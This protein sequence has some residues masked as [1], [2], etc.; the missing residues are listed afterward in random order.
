MIHLQRVFRF[1][2]L[3]LAVLTSSLTSYGQNTGKSKK[4]DSQLEIGRAIQVFRSV[5]AGVETLYVDTVD[6]KGISARGINTMLSQLD[7]YTE[8]MTDNESKDFIFMTTGAY[9]G[10]GAYIQ[11]KDSA[12]Y[13]QMPMPGTPAEKSGLKMGDKFVVIEGVPVVPATAT[14]V[15]GLLKGQ[16]GTKVKVKILRL[17][18]TKEREFT[19]TRDN[20]VV[21]QVVHRGIYR[22]NIGYIR[23]SSF[24]NKSAEDVRKA[25]NELNSTRKLKS[26][27]LDLRGNGGGV[28]D[29]AIKILGMFLPEKTLVLYTEG[30]LPETSQKYYT[31]DKPIDTNIPVVVLINGGSASASEIVSGAMQDLDRGVVLGSKSF[32]KGLVQSTRP[33]PNKGILKVTIARYYIP[34]GRCIQQLDY[35]HRNPDG[36]VASVP[37][38]LANQ[39]KTKNGRIV[40]DGGGIRPDLEIQDEILPVSVFN[41]IRGGYIFEFANKLFVN[42]KGTA[43]PQ[44]V[45]DIGVTDKDF[46]DFLT[47]LEEQKFEYGKLSLNALNRLRE[48]AEFEGYKEQSKE[49]FKELEKALSPSL[50][51]DL[52]QH[53]DMIISQLRSSLASHYFGM[54]GQY[55]VGLESDPTFEKALEILSNKETYR[56]LL[57]PQRD[58]KNIK[59]QK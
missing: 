18:E 33:L 34:S 35:S 38:S 30:K 20:V 42:R 52:A 59:V 17:G 49:A 15:S 54:S 6:I 28:M 16:V 58:S 32:G 1:S 57:T 48:L 47:Y 23:L 25:Y 21:D 40:K 5:L 10:I 36:S 29:D 8:Y 46:E 39:F 41:M 37:D 55:T 3:L 50:R 27:I 31:T 4:A 7:P 14:K 12:V 13:V 11:E 43:A 2:I 53:K 44:S 19:L 26:L 56:K 9:G 45:Q 24:T 51:K 22:D